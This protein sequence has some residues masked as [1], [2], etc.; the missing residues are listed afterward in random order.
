MVRK[1]QAAME[2]LTTY[3][4]AILILVIVM[5]ALLYLGV[6]NASGRVPERCSLPAGMSCGSIL[7]KTASSSSNDIQ[8]SSMTITNNMGERIQICGV[9]CIESGTALAVP[10]LPRGANCGEG[11]GANQD[12]SLEPGQTAQLNQ[13]Q[14]DVPAGGGITIVAGYCV[15]AAGDVKLN[16]PAGKTAHVDLWVYYV[17]ASDPVV[18]T[19]ANARSMTGD[20]LIS[21]VPG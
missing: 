19:M 14:L 10:A 15:V 2:Y 20:A 11:S 9:R 5:G 17:K 4:W 18:G 3:G 7:L 16:I 6:F 8:F 1:G 13:A 12:A 21:I